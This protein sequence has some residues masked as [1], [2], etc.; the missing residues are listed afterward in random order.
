MNAHSSMARRDGMAACVLTLAVAALLFTW[1]PSLRTG[2]SPPRL[3]PPVIIYCPATLTAGYHQAYYDEWN[4]A[5]TPS[6]IALSAAMM[7]PRAKRGQSPAVTPPLDMAHSLFRFP[8]TRSMERYDQITV[9]TPPR[10]MTPM[11]PQRLAAPALARHPSP[12]PPSCRVELIGDWQG[13]SV[14]LAPMSTLSEPAGPWSF[15]AVLLY[16]QTGQVQHALLES[17]VLDQP[18][19]DKVAR[20]LYQCRVTPGNASGEG[21][22]TVSGPGRS[23]RP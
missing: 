2:F 23:S 5:H 15:T 19:R 6:L 12:A 10:S 7:L 21:R 20:R 14:D 1:A 22:L 3:A 13:R 9:M 16:D 4:A 17:A 18:L 11:A 8:D